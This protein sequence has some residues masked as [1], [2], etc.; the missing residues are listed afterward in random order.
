MEFEVLPNPRMIRVIGKR[1]GV[2]DL[3]MVTSDG[4]TIS[5][6]VHVVYDLDLLRAQLR[7]VF[8]DASLQLG[9]IREHV[10]VEGEA[11]STEQACRIVKT[12]ENYLA[13]AQVSHKVRGRQKGT[14]GGRVPVPPNAP[15]PPSKPGTAGADPSQDADAEPA[16]Y[17]SAAGPEAEGNLETEAAF[18]RPRVVNLIRV[19]GLHQVML[20]VRVAELNRSAV[21]EI[22]ADFLAVDPN[23]GNI[24]GTS[25]GGGAVSALGVLGL[26]GLTGV[27]Q[28]ATGPSTTAFG[29]FPSGDFELL[30]RALRRNSM[31]SILAEPNLIAMSGQTASFL[32]GGEF[33]VPVPQ[34][35]GGVNGTF[36]TIEWKEFGVQLNFTPYVMADEMIRL[37]V[38]PEVSSIDEALGTV[39]QNTVVPG[40]STRRANTTVEL[41]QG[42]T[43]A[44]AGLLQVELEGSTSRIPGLGDVPIIGTMF[45]NNSHR[46]VEKELLVLVTPCLVAP[47]NGN[48]VP[49]LPGASVEDPTDLEFYLL[50]RME[51]R[52]GRNH[53]STTGGTRTVRR[54]SGGDLCE[55]DARR[56]FQWNSSPWSPERHHRGEP[57]SSA[58]NCSTT[59][60]EFPVGR[61]S[62]TPPSIPAVLSRSSSGSSS[63]ARSVVRTWAAT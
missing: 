33:A 7:Q 22:G 47:M 51:G 62:W 2:S 1:I 58:R 17:P 43:L 59:L 48:Q 3:S 30:I 23:T 5:Y 44:I 8:P 13:S 25:V 29:V 6:E 32:A 4:Q 34:T 53:R 15:L 24:F 10:V 56:D 31:L 18:A 11:R 26:G 46:R 54:G 20:Q 40:I 21:R 60:N 42:Q 36:F 39:I 63:W 57:W 28:G 45:S 16:P 55:P 38:Q 14:P 35:G 52:T 19:P 37:H 41:R 50:G 12:V 27:A 61:S 9:Q 49:P